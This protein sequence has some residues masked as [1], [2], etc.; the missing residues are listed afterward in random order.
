MFKAVLFA[1]DGTW[2]TD[3]RESESIEA[4]QERLADQGSRWFFYPFHAVILD[5]GPTTFDTQRILDAAWPF[6]H[7]KGKTIR[8]FGR[9]IE[10]MS[11]ES[12]A[13]ILG[14]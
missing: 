9:L 5:K 3:Y 4:V 14:D 1:T 12:L 6:E 11:Q 7:M 8:S 10:N 2:V 13:L